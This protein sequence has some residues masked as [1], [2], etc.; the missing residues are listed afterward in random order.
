[1]PLTLNLV[2]VCKTVLELMEVVSPPMKQK[3][4]FAARHFVG[5]L[6]IKVSA[7]VNVV[8]KVVEVTSN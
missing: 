7:V 6:E 8:G 1:M 5:C 2:A 4:A 3:M